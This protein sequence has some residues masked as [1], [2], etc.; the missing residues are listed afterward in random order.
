MK[1]LK[2][3]AFAAVFALIAGGCG[4]HS[5]IAGS[6]I[7]GSCN[8]ATGECDNDSVAVI[9]TTSMAQMMGA[10]PT[11]DD[12]RAPIKS[13]TLSTM[14]RPISQER[15]R[16]VYLPRFADGE[17]VVTFETHTDSM[18]MYINSPEQLN[19]LT[20]AEAEFDLMGNESSVIFT[21]EAPREIS[22]AMMEELFGEVD[23][24]INTIEQSI[25]YDANTSEIFERYYQNA[26]GSGFFADGR[27]SKSIEHQNTNW[28][29]DTMV[30]EYE[31]L[32]SAQEAKYIQSPDMHYTI[33][34]RVMKQ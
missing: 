6:G 17:Y 14:M 2:A 34:W 9:D 10:F 31:Y 23:D 32:F 22:Y 27:C 25:E 5:G 13:Y 3:A 7:V 19:D 20:R 15:V 21:I 1:D 11:Y 24:E 4:G 8:N 30:G 33:Q 16:D 18:D 29:C 12:A 28:E 26:L